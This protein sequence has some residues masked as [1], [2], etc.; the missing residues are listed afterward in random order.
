MVATLSLLVLDFVTHQHLVIVAIYVF[1]NQ[2][3]HFS[4]G[5]TKKA[6]QAKPPHNCWLKSSLGQ[7]KQNKDR[8]SGSTE[9]N[10]DACFPVPTQPW[11][12][13]NLSITQRVKVLIN[14][15]TLD[16]KITQI[17]TFTPK[18]ITPGVSRIGL[19][20][21][22]MHSEGLHGLR[23]AESVGLHS[24]LFP[25]TTAM[26]AT[27]NISM[28]AEMASIMAVEARA[29]H[30]YANSIGK[31]LTKGAGLF[32]W[33][34]TMN[35]GRDPRWGRFQE[36]VSEDP[37]LNG[38]YSATFVSHF[39]ST[40]G[41]KYPAVAAT[42]KH[43]IAYSLEKYGGVTR[44]TFNAVVS[45][46]D[47]Q[48]SYLPGFKACVTQGKPAEVMCSYNSINGIPS[49]LHGDL[50]NDLLRKKWG[51]Q[52]F[53]VSDQDAV[54]D[55][56]ASHHYS[57]NASAASAS[58]IKAGC[59]QNDGVTYVHNVGQAVK[60]GLMKESDI[61]VAL[62][63]IMTVRFQL[64]MFDPQDLNPWN[65]IPI[66]VL[67]SDNHMDAVLRAAR[68]AICLLENKKNVLP[69]S[70]KNGLRIAMIGPVAN[71]DGVQ[72]G[73]KSDYSPS[74]I[75]NLYEGL[76][77]KVKAFNGQVNL[78]VGC[79][80]CNVK[81]G[82]CDKDIPAAVALAKTADVTILTVGIDNSIESEGKDRVTI[83]LP[84]GQME[85]VK[86]IMSAAKG[87][88][89]VAI[90]NGGPLAIDW[91]K[92]NADTVIE[93]FVLGEKAGTAFADVLFGDVNPSGVLPFTIY[94]ANYINL[95]NM[96][97]MAMRAGAGRTYRFYQGEPLWPF[98][99]G[100]SYTTFS[101]VWH[102]NTNKRQDT[103]IK[104]I[105]TTLEVMKEELQYD[106]NVT[107]TGLVP[108]SKAVMAFI[109]GPLSS[110]DGPIK[111]LFGVEK[112]FL[113]PGQSAIIKFTDKL[114]WC[115]FCTVTSAGRRVVAP[116]EYI[117]TIGG[118]GGSNEKRW[119]K[120]KIQAMVR[121]TG[122]EI[123]VPL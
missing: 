86:K 107:N 91:V 59:D 76:V 98:G 5:H 9:G 22:A 38:A 30:N 106:V 26:A 40:N 123:N 2:N 19:P 6:K 67:E 56:W 53:V 68:E 35:L 36:S 45:E 49:C 12:N 119:K 60:D 33:S 87:P 69:L 96:T 23:N 92:D 64:G 116:G 105:K 95:V 42:C 71:D 58:A 81:S 84:E 112:V 52:G 44:H 31:K 74:N 8:I 93:A 108:G 17:S 11:C 43:W 18:G 75:T 32:Y 7:K 28:I 85:L 55:A 100:L 3:A 25:Q 83:G 113:K 48:E 97:D 51:F 118:D 61:D 46:Q 99:H 54:H 121:L 21:C 89:V 13:V 104:Q 27:G 65:Q 94:P 47:M 4:P 50:Q 41:T 10:D 57:A 82:D 73:A 72:K 39:Q 70:K 115:P 101:L 110:S 20:S 120:P 80:S 34:P 79:K 14:T 122:D 90:V 1:Q 88:V 114:Q 78:S 16:E 111:Q 117:I 15:L 62:T 66:S 24:S 63:R 102:N 77:N 37:W 109:R 29:L 103:E